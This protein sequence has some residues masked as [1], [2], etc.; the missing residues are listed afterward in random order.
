M[1]A[2]TEHVHLLNHSRKVLAKTPEYDR[3]VPFLQY[4]RLEA[5]S[6]ALLS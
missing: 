3:E 1:L 5:M 2:L 4:Q 6:Q